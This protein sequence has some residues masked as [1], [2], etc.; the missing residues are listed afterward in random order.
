MAR[1]L[2]EKTKQL[3]KERWYYWKASQL[4][5]NWRSRCKKVKGDIDSVPTRQQIEDWLNLTPL[6]CY[7]TGKEVIK[8]KMEVDHKRPISNGGS[9]GFNNL[10]ITSK[11]L[12]SAKG[13]MSEKEFK[14]L[15]KL[16]SKWED[17]G[18]QLLNRLIAANNVF[19]R[20]RK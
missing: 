16:I 3:K 19:R 2:S 12:N 15:L 7:L 8:S 4:R 10:G 11:R 18:D 1:K 9:Y 14:G 6:K 20:R 17:K 13:N 5:S